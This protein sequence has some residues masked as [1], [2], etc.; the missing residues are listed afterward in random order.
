MKIPAILALVAFTALYFL[1]G[2]FGFAMSAFC[3]DA[4]TEP[5]AWQCFTLIN[6]LAS[7]PSL[8]CIIGGTVLLFMRRYKLA[9]IVAAVP[10]L[11]AVIFLTVVFFTNASYLPKG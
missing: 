3:F 10:A 1:I 6:L 5:E 4:G 11:I 2:G 9:I 7:V 8:L